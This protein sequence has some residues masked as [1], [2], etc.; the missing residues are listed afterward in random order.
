MDSPSARLRRL[1][2]QESYYREMIRKIQAAPA[3][4]VPPGR[5]KLAGPLLDE[6]HDWMWRRI[7]ER[8]PD[9]SRAMRYGSAYVSDGWDSCDSLPFA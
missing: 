5:K 8:D 6:T 1:E 7:D 4:Y 9:G 2:H 3:G